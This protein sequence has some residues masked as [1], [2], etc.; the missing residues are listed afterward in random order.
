[1]ADSI[2]GEWTAM[3]DP[4]V[5]DDAH[6]TFYSQSTCVFR[7]PESDT[8]IYMGDR[9]NEDDLSNSRYIWLPIEFDGQG[10]MSISFVD[11]WK[12]ER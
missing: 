8:W 10:G 9:W 1:M 5:G 11:E 4:C 3:G 12:L 6:T 7:D 2:F